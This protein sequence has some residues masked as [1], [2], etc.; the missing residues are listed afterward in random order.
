M[1]KMAQ[2]TTGDADT[3]VSTK[4]VERLADAEGVAADELDPIYDYV[5]LEALDALIERGDPSLSV[6]WTMNGYLIAADGTGEVQV[7]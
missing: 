2:A 1:S 3:P 7:E 5:D 4:L 6:R